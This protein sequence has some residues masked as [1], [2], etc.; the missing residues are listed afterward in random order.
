MKSVN[1]SY[2]T[3]DYQSIEDINALRDLCIK[4]KYPN[5]VKFIDLCIQKQEKILPRVR[6]RSLSNTSRKK[7][8]KRGIRNKFHTYYKEMAVCLNVLYLVVT[9]QTNDVSDGF[10]ANLD[11]HYRIINKLFKHLKYCYINRLRTELGVIQFYMRNIFFANY[12]HRNEKFQNNFDL[13]L[14]IFQKQGKRYNLLARHSELL[15]DSY[16]A[17]AS[18][19]HTHH[20]EYE[21]KTHVRIKEYKLISTDHFKLYHLASIVSSYLKGIR[22]HIL[23]EEISTFNQLMRRRRKELEVINRKTPIGSLV[24]LRDLYFDH[25]FDEEDD[26]K[27]CVGITL[28]NI[29]GDDGYINQGM[30]VEVLYEGKVDYFRIKH[31]EVVNEKH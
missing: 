24:K 5:A 3:V 16:N 18:Y 22:T 12:V 30:V 28:S 27:S 11:N 13:R 8:K 21:F 25:Y 6:Q 2:A 20:L 4:S 9:G 31:L 17:Y 19:I 23:P 26:V 29:H 1:N 15:K 10:V 14:K 7:K